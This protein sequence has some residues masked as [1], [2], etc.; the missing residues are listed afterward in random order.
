VKATGHKLRHAAVQGLR[1]LVQVSVIALITAMAYLGLYGHYRATRTLEEEIE[2]TGT[3]AAVLARY[4]HHIR[5]MDNP[6]QFLD[7]NKGTVWSSIVLGVDVTDPLAAAEA[8]AAGKTIY[9]PLLASILIPVAVALVLGKVFCSWICPANLLFEITGKLRGVLRFAEL[10]PADV[11]FSYANKYVLLAVG[12]AIA[13]IVGLPI[14]ALVYP[15]AAMSRLLHGWVFGTPTGGILTVLGAIVVFELIV[16]PRWWCRTMCPGGALYGLIGWPRLLRVKLD[17][18]RCTECGKC[19]P[20]CEPGLDPVRQSSG[21]ECDN[22]GACIRR[23]PET[24]LGFGVGFPRLEGTKTNRERR[25]TTKTATTATALAIV[26]LAPAT[27]H[28]HHILGLPHYS[29]KENYPQAPVLEYPATTGP[30][31]VLL[32]SYPGKPNPGEQVNLVFDIKNT[33]TGKRYQR[34]IGIRVVQTFTFGNNREILSA[35]K[36]PVGDVLYKVY[37]TFPEDGEYV[38]ELSM[39]VEGREETIG[40]LMVVGDPSP[41]TSIIITLG[42]GLAVFLISVRAIKKK[43]DRRT[44]AA[45]ETPSHDQ[46][47]GTETA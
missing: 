31:S 6:Q 9:G 39:D 15:P 28:G 24:A 32:Q 2:Q 7:R 44:R 36:N 4:D 21:I 41:T 13:A 16:S 11:K 37:P 12:L 38:V 46:R 3:R 14:F 20:A 34:P 19:K 33:E 42:C 30:Y 8:I 17:A 29:Y 26:L 43:R 45:S 23:C 47:S 25:S 10:P 1:R 27:V 35:T 18:A 5:A 22:C 40:F